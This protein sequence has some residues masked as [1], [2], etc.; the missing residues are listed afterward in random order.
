MPG[1]AGVER[2]LIGRPESVDALR[3][4][5]D[6]ARDGRGGFTVIEGEAG[7]GKTTLVEGLVR[8]ARSKGLHV[9][10]ARAPSLEN[11]PP[12]HLVREALASRVRSAERP[13]ASLP[14]LAFIP[15]AI[16]SGGGSDDPSDERGPEAWLVEDHL[17]ESFGAGGETTAGGRPR[18]DS[19]LAGELLAEGNNSPTVL[20]LE[21]VHLADEGSLDALGILAPQLA[22]QPLWVVVSRLPLS[23][24]PGPR[25]ARLEAIERSAEAETVVVRPFSLAE[26]TE[27]VRTVERGAEVRDEEVTRWYSQSGGNPLFLEQ[28]ARRRSAIRTEP[29]ARP[30]GNPE[31]FADYLAGQL[32]GL[33]P[34]QE[35]VLAVASI[36]GREFPFA[37]LL[38][39]SGEE[40]EALAETVQDLVGRGAL[41]ER[42]EEIIEFPRDDLRLQIYGRLTEA[43]RRLLHRKAGEALEAYASADEATVYAL[44]RHY[45]VGK[46]DDKA[47]AYNRL[48]GELAARA[49]A[50]QVSREHYDRAMEC[51][52]RM[53][54]RDPVTELEMALEIAVQLDRLG[55]LDAAE[56]VL[57]SALPP[58]DTPSVPPA[59]RAVARI[60]LAR[61]YSDQGRWDDVEKITTELM[62][63][64]DPAWSA[65]TRLAL[66]RLRGELLYY[67]GRYPE[68]LE[69][70][71][72]ALAIAHEE[73]DAREVA[74]E[75]VRRANVLG[76]IP[77][78]FEEAVADYKRVCR[79]LIER[80][81]LGEAA[82]TL[83][84]LGVVLSQYGRT[85]EGLTALE[86]AKQLAEKAGDPRRLGWS[87]FNIADLERERGNLVGAR[88]A[89]RRAR[90]ILEKV[91][92]RFGLVQT[93]IVEGK[94]LLQ[95]GDLA[96]A[97]TEL[98]EAYR[99]VRE[100]N[101][102]AD[103]AE[104]VLR[105]A[106][107]ALARGDT[108]SV[109]AR[110]QELARL[111]IDRLR[112]DLI[113]DHR[114]FLQRMREGGGAT[115]A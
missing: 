84:Y 19:E 41:R 63:M 29:A 57:K 112:P 31:E 89:N 12:Y 30:R 5:G 60:S 77:G 42:P 14:P 20:V 93:E 100:L 104:V 48:A 43:R 91:G 35:R 71:D 75:T 3:R 82:Y 51:Q 88:S 103:E 108:A 96:A 22:T 15:T 97:Q 47:A 95:A 52:R 17:M 106:E 59:L 2:P 56:S 74:L 21:D 69:Q 99:L 34:E 39:A 28:L 115:G 67:Y 94:I 86:E 36:L 79:T 6:A 11:P 98:L 65:R 111:G 101:V 90:E 55:E 109:E 78:R 26:A 102:P 24:L 18:M 8:E 45:Y 105:L 9:L 46:V 66:H 81:D 61:I 49:F 68:S 73:H 44:A 27:F 114:R 80:G 7:V 54:P 16:R 58:A 107:L 92:D 76:M 1:A 37:L 33:A 110:A 62:P 4:R 113:D 83:I 50:P 38:R 40:E 64:S 32:S 70:H 85:D 10:F 13:R 25:R 53:K 23:A 87:L 72:R